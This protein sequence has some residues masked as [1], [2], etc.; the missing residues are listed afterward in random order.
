MSEAE[1]NEL[2]EDANKVEAIRE[3]LKV[4][5]TNSVKATFIIDALA[6]AEKVDVSD[7]EVTQLLYF[8]AL[9]MGQ[10]P[11]NVIKQYQEAGYLPAIK[12]SIIEEKVI[13]KLFD[14]KLA[15]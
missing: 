12:M 7:Q 13:S 4:D 11:Q 1:I 10:N 9:Q 8:E 3:E 2:K 6:K 5:A 14:E 15:K